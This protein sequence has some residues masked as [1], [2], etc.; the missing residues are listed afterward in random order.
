MKNYTGL[1]PQNINAIIDSSSFDRVKL[2]N[3][4]TKI[5]TYFDNKKITSFELEKLLN[6]NENNNFNLLKD[7]ALIGNK[8]KTNKFLSDTII[9]SEK[10]ILYLAI[11]N[12][13][14]NKLYETCKHIKSSNLDD[15]INSIK[16]PVFWKD[17]AT[18]K[19]QA[20]KWNLNKIKKIL[21]ETYNLEIRIKSNSQIDKS[22]LMKKLL[23]DVCKMANS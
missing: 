18:F 2:N 20:T 3:E 8:F 14:L 10:I 17:K 4:L 23:I 19:I 9:T 22:L 11:I 7:E 5:V 16:P 12:Q 15:T 21:N 13:R 6:I 1:T